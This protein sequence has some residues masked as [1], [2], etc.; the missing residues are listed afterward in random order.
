MPVEPIIEFKQGNSVVTSLFWFIVRRWL[1]MLTLILSGLY[2]TDTSFTDLGVN[3][4]ICRKV[5]V[6]V[7]GKVLIF[8]GDGSWVNRR[9][10]FTK[11][12]MNHFQSQPGCCCIAR[13]FL[14]PTRFL[15]SGNVCSDHLGSLLF[16]AECCDYECGC[17]LSCIL[18]VF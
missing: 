8:A 3:I 4:F 14:R 16:C 18:T 7:V 15:W 6:I 2:Q 1:L 11:I 13:S 17:K 9:T 5:D 10:G 12:A